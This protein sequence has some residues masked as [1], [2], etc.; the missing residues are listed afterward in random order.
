[1]NSKKIPPGT[2]LV[3]GRNSVNEL[4]RWNKNRIIKIYSSKKAEKLD[5]SPR[6]IESV[7]FDY[8]SELS[9]SDSH[10][11]IAA[12]IQDTSS[13][14][15]FKQHLK[16]L[17]SKSNPKIL[18]LSVV[19]DPHHLGAAFRAAEV[20]GIDLVVFGQSN[21]TSLTPVV[22][23]VS[24]GATELVPYCQVSNVNEAIRKA[25]DA[26]FWIVAAEPPD[27]NQQ[28]QSLESFEFPEKSLIVFGAEGEGLPRLTKELSDF[29]VYIRQK[30]KIDSLS[31]SQAISIFMY[32][33]TKS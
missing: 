23:K 1:M 14:I 16:N 32:A 5:L 21:S 28:G 15:S 24:V 11:G 10:Q 27:S 8:I 30:G 4:I 17:E 13:E 18:M 3:I 26:H 33:C 22:S 29:Q 7:D 19:Q 20:F 31:L 9:N 25:K 12:L 6:L 2:R